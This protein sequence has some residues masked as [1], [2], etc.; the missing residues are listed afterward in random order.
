MSATEGYSTAPIMVMLRACLIA[1]VTLMTLLG[2]AAAA[3][4]VAARAGCEPLALHATQE[5]TIGQDWANEARLLY[6]QVAASILP[7]GW[8]PT[9]RPRGA[10]HRAAGARRSTLRFALGA[11]APH[12]LMHRR[13][14]FSF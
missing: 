1:V 6:C 12:R 10:V 13:T 9:P 2:P 3:E 5:D 11:A 14:E 4:R 8:S 7:E